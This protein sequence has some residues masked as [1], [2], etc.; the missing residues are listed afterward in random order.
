MTTATTEPFPSPRA[1]PELAS[2]QHLGLTVRDVVASEAWYANALELVRAFVDPHP[3]DDGYA[4][5]T[6]RPGSGLFIGLHRHPEADRERFSPRRTGLDHLAVQLPSRSTIDEWVAHFEALGVEHEAVVEKSEPVPFALVLARD[7][8][9][10]PVEL[11]WL[12]T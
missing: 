7:P 4:V 10:I 8:D 3:N 6:T 11:F 2:L 5:V 9:G 1:I 12:E